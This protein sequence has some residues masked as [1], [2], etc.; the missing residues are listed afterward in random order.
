MAT[1]SGVIVP[2]VTPFNRDENQSI[3]Y[4]AGEQLVEKLIAGGAT[5]DSQRRAGGGSIGWSQ[6]R[7][8]NKGSRTIDEQFD[9]RARACDPTS[10][11]AERF[12]QCTDPHVAIKARDRHRCEHCVRFIDDE[13]GIVL[14]TQLLQLFQGRRIAILGDMLELGAE[15]PR[16][17]KELAAHLD[18]I[19]AR[20]HLR[21]SHERSVDDC[22]PHRRD[23][24]GIERDV[25][26]AR[27]DM[28]QRQLCQWAE[29]TSARGLV[30]GELDSA[31]VDLVLDRLKAETAS[32]KVG[33]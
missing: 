14:D 20:S 13:Q 27:V 26:T 22:A 17:H 21:H 16:Y 32:A 8:K 9:Q 24:C 1:F 15:A 23:A 30:D 11:R 19:G 31:G 6:C 3:N 5:I 29:I 2:M 7:R 18:G 25:I 10:Q 33:G 28:P 12:G 4:E